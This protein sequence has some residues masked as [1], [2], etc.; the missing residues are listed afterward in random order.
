MIPANPIPFDPMQGCPHCRWLDTNLGR[1]LD[2]KCDL[3]QKIEDMQVDHQL[4]QRVARDTSTMLREV[5][6]VLGADDEDDPVE[7]ARSR[8]EEIA[9]LEMASVFDGPFI[10]VNGAGNRFR[11]WGLSGP[12]WTPDKSLAL[13]FARRVDAEQFCAEDEDAWGIR[14]VGWE[15]SH[16]HKKR[17]SAYRVL[18][19]GQLQTEEVI[20]DGEP[21]TIYQGEDGSLWA[22]PVDEFN[23]GRFEP[24][25][26][27][28]DHP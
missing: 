16:R 17:G 7:I 23:D 14:P 21:L 25:S 9:E 26:T 3:H 27:D 28:G 15:P 22:R 5:R 8:I 12:E 20:G 10:I 6:N 19:R 11:C 2:Q 13:W 18:G 4:E 1:V 24:L